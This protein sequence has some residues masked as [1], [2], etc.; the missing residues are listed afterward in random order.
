MC[1]RIRIRMSFSAT[2]GSD[3]HPAKYEITAFNEAMCITPYSD[4]NHLLLKLLLQ[5]PD[6]QLSLS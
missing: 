4:P 6:L 1:E 3:M 5:S 2:I